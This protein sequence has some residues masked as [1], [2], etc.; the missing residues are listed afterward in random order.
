MSGEVGAFAHVRASRTRAAAD[1]VD[2]EVVRAQRRGTLLLVVGLAVVLLSGAEAASAF[3]TANTIDEHATYKQHGRLL[4]VSGPIR[5]T[6]G[7]RV[8]IGVA[9]RQP[10]TAARAPEPVEGPVHGQGPALAGQGARPPRHPLRGWPR[11][12]LL[13]GTDASRTPRHR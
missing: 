6:R 4:L 3:I 1:R 11:S 9:V 2:A 7:E 13:R 12:S 10:A 5:C 8:A